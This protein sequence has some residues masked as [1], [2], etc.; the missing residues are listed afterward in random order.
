[1]NIKTLRQE[2][3]QQG[4]QRKDLKSNP[5]TQFIHWFQQAQQV[6]VL[7]PNAMTLST[8]DYQG[9]P[10]NRIVLLKE[11]NETGLLFFTNYTSKKAQQ[12]QNNPHVALLLFWPELARQIKVQGNIEKTSTQES[13][14]YFHSR[15][16]GSQL[17]AWASE[18]SKVISSRAILEQRLQALTIQYQDKIIPLPPHWGGYKVKP[19]LFEFWQG[20]ENRLHDR[21][22]YTLMEDYTWEINRLSP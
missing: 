18:Q 3:T 4:L 2:Y 11:I 19:Y 14:A 7:E 17:G 13:E 15:P 6:Q 5:T 9:R 10:D 20:R 8:V 21:F 12:M 1:M 16:K 22:Q